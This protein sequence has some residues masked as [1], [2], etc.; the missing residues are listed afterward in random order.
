MRIGVD[1]RPLCLPHTGIGRYTSSLLARL[2]AHREHHWF[3]YTIEPPPV[4]WNAPNVDVRTF[5]ASSLPARLGPLA[6][7]WQFPAW[8]R[9]D[10]LD[11]YWSPRHHLPLRSMA[12]PAVVTIHDFAWRVVPATMPLP[13]V[14]GER[15]LTPVALRRARRI[16]AVSDATRRDILS[17][18]PDLAPKIDT[19]LEASNLGN[20]AVPA[21]STEDFVL[22][23]GTIEPR[24]NQRRLLEAYAIARREETDLPRLILVGGQ[25]W[26]MPAIQTLIDAQGLGDLVEYR[27][28][29]SDAE[30]AQLYAQCR[31][32]LQPSLHEGFALPL[33]E[34]M[35]YGKPA[36]TSNVSAMPE[37]VGAAGLLVEPTSVSSITEAILRL[38]RDQVLYDT[39]ARE[40]QAR[41]A[42][43]SWDRAAA[44][45]LAILTGA[46]N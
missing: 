35:G 29:C 44:E 21:A 10:A 5:S 9:Q 45:T 20:A 8:A 7:H 19:V 25:G 17:A 3:L 32:V 26:K 41:A 14:F 30:L 22:S 12:T 27:P 16:I 4:C 39:L 46:S 43:F 18:Y 23:V 33:I 40:A 24:K 15:L 1:A 34:A 13:R 6:L 28:S 2:C 36:I 38:S 11:V 31:F 42:L 37:V